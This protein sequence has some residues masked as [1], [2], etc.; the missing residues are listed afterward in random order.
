MLCTR[1][2]QKNERLT[3]TRCKVMERYF[4]NIEIKKMKK[5]KYQTTY[6]F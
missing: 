6:N 1:D 2:S 5:M 4:M 3:E